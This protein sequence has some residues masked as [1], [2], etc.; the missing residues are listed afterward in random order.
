M[1]LLLSTLIEDDISI[2]NSINTI[3]F[4]ITGVDK[5]VRSIS[6]AELVSNVHGCRNR[7]K[8]GRRI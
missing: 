7:H 4:D 3:E 5:N 6:H 1:T 2:T 8:G